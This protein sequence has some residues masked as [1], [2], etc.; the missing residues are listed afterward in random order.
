MGFKPLLHL[1][2]CCSSY[3]IV[4]KTLAHAFLLLILCLF[5]Q[6]RADTGDQVDRVDPPYL[7]LLMITPG[8]VFWVYFKSC[9]LIPSQECDTD[10]PHT[11]CRPV[12]PL[13]S[14]PLSYRERAV[15]P[16]YCNT[17]P[18]HRLPHYHG[19]NEKDEMTYACEK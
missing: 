15:Y 10:S 1:L 8:I 2:F 5:G 18:I 19:S 12:D 7:F 16:R 9:N 11:T 3:V 17:D 4:N 13:D 6:A 14:L